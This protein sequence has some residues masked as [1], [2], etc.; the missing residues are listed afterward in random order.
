MGEL[1]LKPTKEWSY[2]V[3][4]VLCGS[5]R[6]IFT[7]LS[8]NFESVSML[9]A[10]VFLNHK[11]RIP[12][13]ESPLNNS[14]DRIFTLNSSLYSCYKVPQNMRMWGSTRNLSDGP[15]ISLTNGK[16]Y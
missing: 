13:R 14:I 16:K 8:F 10:G 1:S 5:L 6:C 12:N 4:H 9:G 2:F 7:G 15:D 11:M 3:G